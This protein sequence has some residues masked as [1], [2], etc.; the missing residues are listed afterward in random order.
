MIILICFGTLKLMIHVITKA[1]MKYRE[2]SVRAPDEAPNSSIIDKVSN[3]LYKY[4]YSFLRDMFEPMIF[5]N[6]KIL[7]VYKR[8]EKVDDESSDQTQITDDKKWTAKLRA[9][10]SFFR[11]HL[12]ARRYLL[13]V[14]SDILNIVYI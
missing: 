6:E 14:I 5:G 1:M 12:F 2:S 4:G 8:W 7:E 13:S 10:L 3:F 9:M 11:A